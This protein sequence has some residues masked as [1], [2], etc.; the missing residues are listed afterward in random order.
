[1]KAAG[2]IAIVTL[3]L[4]GLDSF[5]ATATNGAAFPPLALPGPGGYDPAVAALDSCNRGGRNVL[6]DVYLINT[7]VSECQQ[8]RTVQARDSGISGQVSTCWSYTSQWTNLE[9][10]AKSIE[11]QAAKTPNGQAAG[12]LMNQAQATLDQARSILITQAVCTNGLINSDQFAANDAT[13]R[14][15][16]TNGGSGS[17]GGGGDG[18]SVGVGTSAPPNNPAV[19]TGPSGPG[20]HY[21]AL[22]PGPAGGIGYR[23]G[24]NACLP[25]GPGG[26]DYC[27]NGPGAWL[28]P[29]CVCGGPSVAQNRASPRW[30]GYVDSHGETQSNPTQGGPDGHANVGPPPAPSRPPPPQISPGSLPTPRVSSPPAGGGGNS[31]TIPPGGVAITLG[32]KPGYYLKDMPYYRGNKFGDNTGPVGVD[33]RLH[34][35]DSKSTLEIPDQ[36]PGGGTVTGTLSPDFGPDG[37]LKELILVIPPGTAAADRVPLFPRATLNGDD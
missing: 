23:P 17:N 34:S 26:Y 35:T 24:A 22:R 21:Q 3:M 7:V 11:Q 29:G 15:G 14:G 20:V 9:L 1:M 27:K 33:V 32:G 25:Q 18:S 16:A 4:A 5:A 19:G 6:G 31:K 13:N 37:Y 10:Q 12:A 36:R 28:P 2:L 30:S 8:N